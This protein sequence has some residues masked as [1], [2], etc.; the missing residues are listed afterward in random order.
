MKKALPYAEIK[1]HSPGTECQLNNQNRDGVFM[2]QEKIAIAGIPAIIWGA[3]SDKVFIHVHG[4]MSRKEYAAFFAEIMEEKGYQTLSF[5]LPEHGERAD[6]HERRCDVW[7]GITDLDVI[8]NFAFARW[9]HVSLYACS[10]GA[11]FSL[12]TYA[13]RA[14]EQCFFQSPIVDMEY[15]IRQMFMWNDVTEERLRQEKE[16]DT[17]IDA[18]RWDYFQY[19]LAHPITKW[20]HPT[21][22]LYGGKDT[23]QSREVITEFAN[24]FS[25]QLTISEASEH[26]FMGDG[27]GEIVK[28]WLVGE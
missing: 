1:N 4:K 8:A 3:P 27:D 19:V 5:D 12:N 28:A 15:M 10:L 16:I 13:D 26:P 18:L 24:R 11:Y 25:C 23:F 9:T 21:T 14:F 6:D 20:P 17:P 2:K 7:N 22:I